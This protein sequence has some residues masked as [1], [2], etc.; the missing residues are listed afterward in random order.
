MSAQNE[1]T[2]R[3]REALY[4]AEVEMRKSKRTVRDTGDLLLGLWIDNVDLEDGIFKP[5]ELD[6]EQLRQA[7]VEAR[8]TS[9]EEALWGQVLEAAKLVANERQP[10]LLDEVLEAKLCWQGRIDTTDLLMALASFPDSIAMQALQ[11]L[12]VTPHLIM[13]AVALK[14]KMLPVYAAGKS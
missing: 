10:K 2:L 3:G 13:T 9:T 1:A 14:L 11:S 7:I 6:E 5:L 12:D 8:Q 4:F